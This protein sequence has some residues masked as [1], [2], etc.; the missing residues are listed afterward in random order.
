M[1]LAG[2]DADSHGT[3]ADAGPRPDSRVAPPDAGMPAQ[4]PVPVGETI[5]R[6]VLEDTTH[7][8][9]TNVPVTFAM[10]FRMGDVPA[11]TV[12][13]ARVAGEGWPTQLDA[14]VTHADGSLRHGLITIVVPSLGADER[15]EVE[16][17]ASTTAGASGAPLDAS[18][19]AMA[20]FTASVDFTSASDHATA[21]FAPGEDRWMSGPLASEWS[22]VSD[23]TVDGRPL[24]VRFD[25]RWY[26]G[27]ARVGVTV[28]ND[29]A[30]EPGPR[31]VTY[32]ATVQV[33]GGEAYAIHGLT[34]YAR[35][36]WHRVVW[37]GEPSGIHVAH[38]ARYVV[39]SGAVA[40]YDTTLTIGDDVI[41]DLAADW[42]NRP[43]DPMAVGMPEPYMP[44]TGGRRDIG[45]LPGWDVV[46][47]LSADARLWPMVEGTADLAG[48]W[49]IHYRDRATGRPP[50]LDDHPRMTIL[51]DPQY[52]GDDAF[53]ECAGSC[54]T[55]MTPDSSHQ[56]S[57]GYLAYLLGGDRAHLEELQFWADYDLFET[58]PDYRHEADGLV[59]PGQVRAQA[60]S[61]RTIAHAAWV[62]PDADPMHAYFVDK[63]QRN[64]DWY[65]ATVV[66][67][68]ESNALGV[69]H[70]FAY[71]DGRGVA[72]WQDDFFTWTVA[73]LVIM[74]FESARELALYKARFPVGRMT[75]PM[76]WVQ[77]GAYELVVREVDGGPVYDWPA[78]AAAN[79]DPAAAG[80]E[81]GSAAMF[82]ALGLR[83]GEVTGYADSAEGYPSNLQPALA[84]AAELGAPG[85]AE[86]WAT[87]AARTITPDYSAEPQFAVVPARP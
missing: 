68:D 47:L 62:T 14:K 1:V 39:R 44:T 28:E 66:H 81:C 57:F 50:T 43:R 26:G 32:D 3:A 55:P 16:L 49:P 53:P 5:T 84:A 18:G 63:V 58:N 67:G 78:T 6:V 72:P 45:P 27:R 41:T 79:L 15:R 48:S 21:T 13:V 75:A 38:D 85:A 61:L 31:N 65:T 69:L 80:T 77:V 25:V 40:A 37:W 12:V 46:Y 9:R 30:F 82:E 2:C 8:A 54:D 36:R 7:S 19:L 10:P 73:Q 23:V 59:F 56:P 71:L 29:W 60:W 24:S 22:S 4:P 52:S 86:A 70:G 33:A 87:F 17:V 64:I 83:Q 35:A 74:G 11:G 20:G 51:G 42:E 76:C 34:H